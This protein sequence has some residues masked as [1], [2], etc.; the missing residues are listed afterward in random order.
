MARSHQIAE[1]PDLSRDRLKTGVHLG[2]QSPDIVAQWPL[3]IGHHITF[4]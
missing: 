2:A 1:S 3:F 4:A